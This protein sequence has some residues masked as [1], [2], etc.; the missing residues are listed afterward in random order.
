ML[1]RV[2]LALVLC[3]ASTPALAN[4]IRWDQNGHYY[5]AQRVS[6]PAGIRW[7]DADEGAVARGAYLA[8]ITSA[9]ENAFVY[10]LVNATYF[11]PESG[12]AAMLGPWIGLWR[13]DMTFQWVSGEPFD[14]ANWSP[15]EPNDYGGDENFVQFFGYGAPSPLWNDF[16]NDGSAH[17][18]HERPIAYM[19]ERDTC[20]ADLTGDGALNFFD[21]QAFLHA[22][23]VG[24]P[25]ADFTHDDMLNF[26]DV[27]G[28]LNLYT[29]G[30]P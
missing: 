19:L 26:F 10:S 6:D 23:A 8:C 20:P 29:G 1:G 9:E 5:A 14:F 12:T 21:V 13:P 7:T 17:I 24:T 16:P 18:G 30:C 27:Q 22:F 11:K 25:I 3:A 2:P 28:F 15:G 4:W